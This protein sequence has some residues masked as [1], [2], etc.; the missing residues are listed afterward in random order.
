MDWAREHVEDIYIGMFEEE[1]Y[2]K[3]KK[4]ENKKPDNNT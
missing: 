4:Q 2:Q 3:Q 1:T